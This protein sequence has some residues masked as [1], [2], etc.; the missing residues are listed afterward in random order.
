MC[1]SDLL[2]PLVHPM[3]H[4]VPSACDQVAINAD[5]TAA[6]ADGQDLIARNAIKR[7]QHVAAPVAWPPL[8]RAHHPAPAL[9][10]AG[11]VRGTI[12]AHEGLESDMNAP[13]ECAP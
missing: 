3:C 6:H 4:R 8:T 11:P 9:R 10:K 5:P 2:N 12:A 7:D 1:S 13:I